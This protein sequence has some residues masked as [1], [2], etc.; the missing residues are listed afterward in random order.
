MSIVAKTY[1]MVDGQVAQAAE[2]NK[3]FDDIYN[4][5]NGN[6]DNTNIKASAGIVDTKLAQITTAG[7]IAASALPGGLGTRGTFTNAD[8]ST[9]VLTITHSLAL[10]APYS[11]P[12]RIFDN[13]G[14]E[15]IPDS[16]VGS[17]N[18][19]AVSIVSYGTIT[20]TYG[21]IY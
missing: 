9:G 2:V 5:V 20:G 17:A 7:K 19:A 6:L 1:T 16:I 21:Y 15:I 11:L 3:N 4:N 18:S 8:L 12:V 14:A 10:A 13:T